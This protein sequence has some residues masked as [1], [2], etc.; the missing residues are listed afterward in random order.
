MEGIQLL[1][2]KEAGLSQSKVKICGYVGQG[3]NF[4]VYILLTS[5]DPQSK[6]PV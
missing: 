5:K 4:R 2:C 1:S 6:G 3:H